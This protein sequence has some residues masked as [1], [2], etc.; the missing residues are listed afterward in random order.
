MRE[1]AQ[2][3]GAG[4]DFEKKLASYTSSLGKPTM[5][6]FSS[7]VISLSIATWEDSKTRFE[8][9]EKVE[10]IEVAVASAMIDK[11]ASQ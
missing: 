11:L 6:R 10:G 9:V 7:G 3:Y 2:R 5:S 4:A 1:L 8:L